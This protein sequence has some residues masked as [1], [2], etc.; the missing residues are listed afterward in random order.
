[1]TINIVFQYILA[2]RALLIFKSATFGANV[3]Q[4]RTKSAISDNVDFLLLM[5]WDRCVIVRQFVSVSRS[6]R[7]DNL[8]V[9]RLTELGPKWLKLSTN[10]TNPGLFQIKFDLKMSWICSI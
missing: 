8:I 4:L 3:G 6:H 5:R 2:Y 7:L 9:H 1:M 10:G